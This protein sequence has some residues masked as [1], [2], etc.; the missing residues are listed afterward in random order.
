[1]WFKRAV[2]SPFVLLAVG[3]CSEIQA[4]EAG[5][6]L[7]APPVT[8]ISAAPIG[9]L[10]GFRFEAPIVPGPTL[11]GPGVFDGSL[12]DLLAV[13]ICEWD[14][15]NCVGA[16]L[17]RITA[18]DPPPA[19]LAVVHG[20]QVY[21]ALWNTGHD[22]L[23]PARNYRLRVMAGPTELG[24]ADLD[25]VASNAGG[26]S[27]TSG[28]VRVVAGSTVP[29]TF[30]IDQG[31]GVRVGP[32]GKQVTLAGGDVILDVPA[33]AV[34]GDVLFTAT[35]AT[36]LPTNGADPVPGTGWDF[37]PDGIVFAKPVT[38]TLKYDRSRIPPGVQE[39][40]LRI[41]KLVNGL[42]VPQNAGTID[43]NAQTASAK[44][45][46]FSIFVLVSRLCRNCS[47]DVQGPVLI[48]VEFLDPNTNTYAPT[49]TINTSASDVVVQSRV[50]I[51]DDNSGADY[52]DV[53]FRSPSGRQM[54]FTCYPYPFRAP[55]TGNDTNGQWD[56][57]STWPQYSESGTWTVQW[58]P[59]RDRTTNWSYYSPAPAGVCDN[60]G[61]GPQCLATVPQVNVVSSPSDLTPATVVAF[62]VSLDVQPR[63]YGASLSVDASGGARPLVFRFHVTDALSG[64][65]PSPNEFFWVRFEGP[66]GQFFDFSQ[67][68]LV[69][70][71]PADGFWECPFTLP[72]NSQDGTWFIRGAYVTDR[73]G[74]LSYFSGGG[75][76]RVGSQL[77]N[78][79]NTC[80]TPPAVTVTSAGDAEAPLVQS[81]VI[82]ATNSDVSTTL[83]I[84]DNLTG[85]TT[86][87]VHYLSATTTQW[88]TCVASRTSGTPT[89]GLYACQITFSALAARGQW[90]LAID[91]WDAAGNRRYYTR[92]A[93]DGFMCYTPVGGGA[94]ICQDF[95]TTDLQLQ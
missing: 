61:A 53:R 55:V 35:P 94:A 83:R 52:I 32:E 41:H 84:T 80:I 21:R 28:L 93:A 64:A 11:N 17:R 91:V 23:D 31:L 62:E 9:G 27:P 70:G 92:R 40:E 22:A 46:G 63:A 87:W 12:A 60:W 36:N 58:A 8:S 7:A 42:Y 90:N 43:L 1:M 59:L 5:P 74:N 54:R 57:S 14:G 26:A 69:Q 30:R 82:A 3:A 19:R 95:G 88:Q 15:A 45:D 85:P 33:G 38:L 44:V 49:L 47:A 73:V 77:C 48:A 50:T 18:Q 4:P 89:D 16:P 76:W 51:T 10:S 13:E 24:Y 75:F 71:T 86:V 79:L 29:V 81:V 65:G 37:G 39:T 6:R 34:T 66:S 25:V 20:A 78:A 72:R 2:V 67:C 68:V 56:C